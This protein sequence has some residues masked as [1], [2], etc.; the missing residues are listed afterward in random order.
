M[1][2]DDFVNGRYQQIR[3][4]VSKSKAIEDFFS[5]LEFG[6]MKVDY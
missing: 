2:I 4:E 1:Q 6:S 5:K 3:N